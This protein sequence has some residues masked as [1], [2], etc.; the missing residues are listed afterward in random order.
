MSL[1]GPDIN[2]DSVVF[3]NYRVYGS[4]LLFIMGTIVFFG[5][6]IVNKFAGLALICVLGTIVCM[7]TGIAYNWHGND[8]ANICVVGTRLVSQVP[9]CVKDPVDGA[10]L[11]DT[12]CEKLDNVTELLQNPENNFY[13]NMT[14]KYDFKCD[15]YFRDNNVTER[16][17]IK[18]IAS[19]TFTEAMWNTY[20]EGGDVVSDSTEESEYNLGGKKPYSY[21]IVDIWTSF[22]L[23]IGIF[24][25]SVTGIMAGSNRSGDL[26]DAQK[27][28]PIG[29][30]MAILS[31]GTVYLL[32]AIL[33]AATV[34]PLLLRD[35]CDITAV[36]DI[37]CVNNIYCS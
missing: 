24:F 22:T 1:F 37:Y 27:S 17:G 8:K 9:N 31:T 34:D 23:I 28:I 15:E 2:D 6:K 33:F 14:T 7:F 5:V 10:E 20:H 25:P 18:G 3:N 13:R 32:S 16:R 30:I 12:F 11:W 35:K 29:T 21:I 36:I 19:G 26:A 4:I